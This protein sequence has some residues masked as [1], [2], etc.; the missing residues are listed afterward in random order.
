[1]PKQRTKPPLAGDGGALAASHLQ[2]EAK[3]IT[4][5]LVRKA[6][7]GRGNIKAL[8]L[9]IERLVPLTRERA[10]PV[11]IPP[12]QD[13]L[14]ITIA[15]K[16]VFESLGAGQLTSGEAQK[17]TAILENQ[18]KAIETYDLEERLLALES[19]PRTR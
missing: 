9:C 19:A 14:Q 2:A 16:A 10:L 18:R 17:L 4:R 3:N 11:N 7:A 13:A 8:R 15:L 6:T 1:M 12:A 5:A